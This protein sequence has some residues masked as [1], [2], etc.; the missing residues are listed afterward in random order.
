MLV[1]VSAFVAGSDH[2]NRGVAC[3]DYVRVRTSA[4]GSLG[5][6][7]LCDGAGSCTSSEIGARGVC[8]WFL[9][10]VVE[11]QA[12]I[13]SLQA[14]DLGAK[15]SREIGLT[16][17]RIAG[18]TGV[19]VGDLSSTFM[20]VI[21]R[22]LVGSLD[23]RL[24][25]VGDGVVAGVGADGRVV[26]SAPDN[27]EFANETVFTTSPSF[28]KSLRVRAGELPHGSGFVAMSDGSGTSLY[29]KSR[30]AL[31]PAVAEMLGWLNEN[32]PDTV[33]AAIDH[34]L[35]EF[36][37]AKTGDDCSLGLMLDRDRSRPFTVELPHPQVRD[38]E[39]KDDKKLKR[40]TKR[41]G[42]KKLRYS[43]R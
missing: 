37:C 30:Q 33:S 8:E 22:R 25:H 40:K 16:L 36:M 4:D 19:K 15:V 7:V 18:E 1:G 31:A 34:N 10:W 39:V 24:L 9:S 12:D 42:L 41:R 26:I 35:R 5:T 14:S 28:E 29:L 32:D 43:Q 2:R 23:Y 38:E 17:R 6:L 11:A 20:A 21:V 3:Q 13:W 27:G